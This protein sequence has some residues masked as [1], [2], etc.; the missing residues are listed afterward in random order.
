MEFN[1]T[2]HL[3]TNLT[4][5]DTNTPCREISISKAAGYYFGVAIKG[6]YL[7]VLY[8]KVK[9]KSKGPRPKCSA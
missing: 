1:E 2:Y 6:V 8:S 5:N 3:C 7:H 9:L 4:V